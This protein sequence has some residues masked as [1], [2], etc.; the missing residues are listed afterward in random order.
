MFKCTLKQNELD[1][2]YL[3]SQTHGPIIMDPIYHK[4]LYNCLLSNTFKLKLGNNTKIFLVESEQ[5]RWKEI[6]GYIMKSGK[7][8]HASCDMA[9]CA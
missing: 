5:A 3:G 6:V 8:D 2:E 9:R 7:V 4:M 1:E